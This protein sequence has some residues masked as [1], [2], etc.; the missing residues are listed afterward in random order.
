VFL[1]ILLRFIELRGLKEKQ[2]EQKS[3]GGS[4]DS[5]EAIPCVLT[6]ESSQLSDLSDLREEVKRRKDR[7]VNVNFVKRER[8]LRNF[9]KSQ[10]LSLSHSQVLSGGLPV[11]EL[12]SIQ[13]QWGRKIKLFPNCSLSQFFKHSILLLSHSSSSS[14]SCLIFLSP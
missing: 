13:V 12:R 2:F 1:P 11:D 6:R 14:S 10:L 3:I 5:G 8:S 7:D 4:S 9:H